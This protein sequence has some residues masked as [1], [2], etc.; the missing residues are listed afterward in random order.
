M[1]RAGRRATIRADAQPDTA[2]LDSITLENFRCF[3]ERQTARLAPLTL[4]VGDNSTGKTSFMALIRA[5]WDVAYGNRVPD[6]KED[7]YDLGS[8][9]DIA[10]HRGQ[11]GGR[12]DTFEAGFEVGLRRRRAT[13]TSA[14][15]ASSERFSVIFERGGTVP[16]P[17]LRRLEQSDLWI[18]DRQ[19]RGE[20]RELR[21]GTCRGS[22]TSANRPLGG[23]LPES[24]RTQYVTQPLLSLLLHVMQTR[25]VENEQSNFSPL[26]KSEKITSNDLSRFWEIVF[27]PEET[28]FETGFGNRRSIERPYASAPVR[29]RPRR[30]Y[31]PARA[32]PDPDGD[33]VPMYL[34]NMSFQ[35][36]R[37]WADLKKAL[38]KFG[39]DSGLFD[40]IDVRRL[41]KG[42]S[43]PF[44]LRVRKF[45]NR[46]KGPPRN[47]IDV[48]YG[49][50]Q[51][52]PVVTELLRRD[53]PSMFLLQQPEV[54]LHPSAQAGLGSLFHAISGPD[55][56]LIVET[57]SDHLIDRVRMDAR[58][59]RGKLKPDDVSILFFERGNLDVRIHSL[60]LDRQ[61][62]VLD[63]PK[64]Y[65]AF[66]ME[67]TRRSLGF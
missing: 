21:I 29:S 8:F 2:A 45:G 5:L 18:E 40:E 42:G 31:D 24:D 56:R 30:T 39:Q 63:A 48:G 50:S 23:G 6:F 55:R 9:D 53:A 58:D 43:E 66:F 44:Q 19:N 46:L 14:E 33:Y 25:I 41:G 51:V 60:R 13:G 65:R 57:H 17:R 35:D 1:T 7:P 38:E 15:G 52:L 27:E 11:R 28:S 67:A 3:R 20:H 37:G 62:N 54:H 16:V 59:S 4:L 36:R 12:A 22:W 49:V 10:H 61:G 26:G 32:T 34:A 47:M 64:A